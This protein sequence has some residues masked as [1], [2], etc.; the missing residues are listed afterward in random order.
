MADTRW[1]CLRKHCWVCLLTFSLF[2]TSLSDSSISLPPAGTIS[3]YVGRF[4]VKNAFILLHSSVLSASLG[5]MATFARIQ[6]N[7]LLHPGLSA[8]E[9]FSQSVGKSIIVWC[10][11]K[12][13]GV[14]G[15]LECP[16]KQNGSG[17]ACRIHERPFSII[18]AFR[19]LCTFMILSRPSK[20]Y[21]PKA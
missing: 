20:P 18:S 15:F 7:V 4:T 11:V 13:V 1:T 6:D 16:L 2:W 14:V 12:E 5:S 19:Y 3:Y 10:M 21:T 17:F 8:S 9:I